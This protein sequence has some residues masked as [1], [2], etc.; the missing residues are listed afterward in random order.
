MSLCQV[1]NQDPQSPKNTD[2]IKGDIIE[3]LRLSGSGVYNH[4]T[5][6]RRQRWNGKVGEMVKTA[7]FG[8]VLR[9][10]QT[11]RV[12]TNIQIPPMGT[13]NY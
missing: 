3:R 9:G 13:E 4:L 12:E 8:N 11:S 5:H 1:P 7:F 6:N 10:V 2:N